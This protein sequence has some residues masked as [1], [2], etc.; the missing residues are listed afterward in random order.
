MG[1]RRKHSSRGERFVKIEFWIMESDAWSSSSPKARALL[2]ELIKRGYGELFNGKIGVSVRDAANAL[3]VTT[4]TAS[5][6]FR[7]LQE[8]GFIIAEH[9]GTF[10]TSKGGKN[11]A[12]EWRLT[13]LPSSSASSFGGAK[14]ATK[15]FMRWQSDADNFPVYDGRSC[16]QKREAK[17]TVSKNASV[18]IR[19]CDST[20]K[21]V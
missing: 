1:N 13:F 15:E 16:R 11:R 5:R 12:T 3:H 9:I 10:D 4:N 6:A 20:Q 2:L 14:P 8:K 19:K 18:G 17:K 21:G 7:E